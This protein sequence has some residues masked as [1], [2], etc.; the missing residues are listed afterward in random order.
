MWR[1]NDI[2]ALHSEYIL[3][4]SMPSRDVKNKCGRI[5]FFINISLYWMKE[6]FLLPWTRCRCGD[7][8]PAWGRASG[9]AGRR[10]RWSCTGRGRPR[11]GRWA[12]SAG[13]SCRISRSLGSGGYTMST[14]YWL[15]TNTLEVVQAVSVKCSDSLKVWHRAAHVSVPT[16]GWQAELKSWQQSLKYLQWPSQAQ[17]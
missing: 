7:R 12:S 17:T 9:T 11:P 5:Y 13:Q 2:F 14:V 6:A 15:R 16:W 8:W 3:L 10:P 1:E 4:L